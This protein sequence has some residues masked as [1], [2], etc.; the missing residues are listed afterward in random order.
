MKNGKIDLRDK[1]NYIVV[2]CAATKPSMDIGAAEIRK[3]HTDPPNS[4]EIVYYYIME[5][6]RNPKCDKR[7][8][9]VFLSFC[10]FLKSQKTHF[11]S[12]LGFSAFTF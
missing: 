7:H 11:L 12:I 1:T 5:S 2:H 6:L 4:S 3:W 10:D 8:F 9:S